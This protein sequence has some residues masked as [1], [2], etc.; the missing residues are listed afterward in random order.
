MLLRRVAAVVP[1]LALLAASLTACSDEAAR[2]ENS[3]LRVDQPTPAAATNE[4][5]ATEA[6]PA[7][8]PTVSATTAGR[9]YRVRSEAA[10]FYDSPGKTK[11]T[12]QYLRRGDVLY[13]EEDGNGFIRTQFVSQTGATVTGWLKVEEVSRLTA[14]P[15]SR[16]APARPAASVPATSSETDVALGPEPT[17]ATSGSG[18]RKA[19]VQAGR[20]YFYNTPDLLTPRRAYCEQGDKVNLGQ[21]QGEAVYVTFTNWEKVTTR[22]WMKKEALRLPE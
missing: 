10:Y 21:E 9:R 8:P 19:V 16:P 17:R 3:E 18:T 6:A 7:P 15:A 4:A 5:A 2:R 22:G 1:V 12:G 14:S 11:P 20:A 13:G